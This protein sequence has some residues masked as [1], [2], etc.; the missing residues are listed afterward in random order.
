MTRRFQAH[1]SA[2]RRVKRYGPK[3]ELGSNMF[4]YLKF[5]LP[6]VFPPAAPGRD[7][8]SGYDSSDDGAGGE[9]RRGGASSIGRGDRY[10]R[11]KSN[12][13]LLA[14]RDWNSPVPTRDSRAKSS[15][16]ANLLSADTYYRERRGIGGGAASRLGGSQMSL[17]SRQSRRSRQHGAIFNHHQV[18]SRCWVVQG[19]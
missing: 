16:E 1:K 11:S 15:S 14:A 19:I 10:T 13:D 8:S 18:R 12:P 17:T 3:S 2:W 5:G 7:G 6:R 4:T 9:R